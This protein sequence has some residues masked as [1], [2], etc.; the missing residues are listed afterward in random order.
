MANKIT[1]SELTRQLKLKSSQVAII[2][3]ISEAELDAED[4][5]A[6]LMENFKHDQIEPIKQFLS[7]LK[8]N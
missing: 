5:D 3:E 7:Q 8:N 2:D 6:A 4:I 1:L